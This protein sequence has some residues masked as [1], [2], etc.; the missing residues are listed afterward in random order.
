MSN[1]IHIEPD[2]SGSLFKLFKSNLKA[3]SIDE[4]Y[5]SPILHVFANNTFASF[6]AVS[7]DISSLVINITT[8]TK[9]SDW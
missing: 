8:D 4:F 5:D 1:I 7:G 6:E 9:H 2:S 3:H